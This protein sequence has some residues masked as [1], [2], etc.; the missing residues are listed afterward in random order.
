MRERIAKVSPRFKAR[1]ASFTYWLY[2]LALVGGGLL[3]DELIVPGNASATAQNVLA[4]EPSFRLGFALDLISTAFYLVTTVLVYDLFQPVNRSLSFLAMV[5]NL[6]GSALHASRAIFQLA[7][8]LVLEGG[9]DVS[10]F[11]VDQLQGLA[12]LFLNLNTQAWETALVFFGAYWLLTGF[13]I[14]R[15]TFLPRMLGALTVVTGLSWLTFLS[16]PL[17]H[18]L[19]P[20]IRVLGVLGEF[21]LMVWLLV[22]G[23]N[24]QRWKEQ[25]SAAGASIRT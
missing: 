15:S 13:L 3:I 2:S 20:G 8:L 16:P 11:K 25:E 18:A 5:F 7:V 22:M 9:H 12:L 10:A 23:V 19:S 1:I 4:H 24:A 6:V 14:F 21:S 17:A